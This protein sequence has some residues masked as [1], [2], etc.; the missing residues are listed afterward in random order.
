MP[1]ARDC[2]SL[3]LALVYVLGSAYSAIWKNILRYIPG[4]IYA[5]SPPA[6]PN[7]VIKLKCRMEYDVCTHLAN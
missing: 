1:S 7:F 5:G 3:R 6:S 4:A 2:M